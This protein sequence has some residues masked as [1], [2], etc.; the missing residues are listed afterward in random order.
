MPVQKRNGT[1]ASS[2]ARAPA[3]DDGSWEGWN[4]KWDSAASR[5]TQRSRGWK[6][7]P[8][9]TSKSRK[10]PEWSAG[11]DREW[12]NKTGTWQ[13]RRDWGTWQDSWSSEKDPGPPGSPNN[14][15]SNLVDVRGDGEDKDELEEDAAPQGLESKQ[16]FDGCLSVPPLT[17]A[18][19][20]TGGSPPPSPPESLPL[21]TLFLP[22]PPVTHSSCVCDLRKVQTSG[23]LDFRFVLRCQAKPDS[24][25]TKPSQVKPNQPATPPNSHSKSFPFLL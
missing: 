12:H 13:D 9:K 4:S 21:S 8:Q 23:V 25:P 6:S 20:L 18:P 3:G 7:S 2:M 22:L 17:P 11:H 14:V 10:K 1:S 5:S 16:L 24:Q 15:D 19:P